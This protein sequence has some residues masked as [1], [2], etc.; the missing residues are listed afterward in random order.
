MAEIVE[1]P[2]VS[3]CTMEPHSGLC[4]GCGRTLA[5]IAVW[6]RLG[7]DERRRIMAALPQRRQAASRGA[8]SA[9]MAEG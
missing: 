7:R 6:A 5:E 3:V 8:S 2:C 4:A 9:P 1:S